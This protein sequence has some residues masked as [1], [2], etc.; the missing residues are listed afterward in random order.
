M[1][2]QCPRLGGLRWIDPREGRGEGRGLPGAIYM[3]N[4]ETVLKGGMVTKTLNLD[5]K[6]LPRSAIGH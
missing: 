1:G 6:S 5:N 3:E 2:D 4:I